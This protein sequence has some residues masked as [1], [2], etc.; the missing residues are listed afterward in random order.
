MAPAGSLLQLLD[1]P[2]DVLVSILSRLPFNERL[3]L[4]GVCRRLR[5]LCAGP[6]QLWRCV[7]VRRRLESGPEETKL[8]LIGRSM[9]LQRGLGEWLA[10]RAAAVEELSLALQ[11]QLLSANQLVPAVVVPQPS[12]L[13]ALHQLT[14]EWPGTAMWTTAARPWPELLPALTKLDF[15]LGTQLCLENQGLSILPSLREFSLS[16]GTLELSACLSPWLPDTV[17]SLW[18][19]AAGIRGIPATVT[20]LTRLRSLVVG[21]NRFG[22]GQKDSLDL[23]PPLGGTLEELNLSETCLRAFPTQVS[24]LTRLKVLYLHNAWH[25]SAALIPSDW[26]A[27]QPLATSLR[28]LSISGN[29]LEALPF[30][31]LGMPRLLGLHVEDNDLAGPLPLAPY[32]RTLRELL[33]DWQAA[34]DSHEALRA[35]TSLSRLVLSGHRAVDLHPDGTLTVRPA[36]SAEPLLAALAAMP[37]LRLVEDIQGEEDVVTAPVAHAMWQMG[38][39]LGPQVALGAAKD[40]NLGWTLTEVEAAEAAEAAQ[41]A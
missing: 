34:L 13:P 18:L 31:V 3:R 10:P 4:S 2:P 41:Q 21:M 26:D 30:A 36:Q 37:A 9:Q 40:S 16:N 17:T 15:G 23:L 6:S 25:R 39:R 35:A 12:G 22:T 20:H 14:I 8:Q 5:Q 29:R 19:S 32:L 7:D 28:F 33:L 11:M 38:R 24:A 1:L 27:L